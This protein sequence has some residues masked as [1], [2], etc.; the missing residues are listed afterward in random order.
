MEANNVAAM[1]EA[2]RNLVDAIRDYHEN[3]A[4]YVGRNILSVLAPQINAA[5]DALAAPLR[6]CDVGTPEEQEERFENYTA[7]HWHLGNT[8]LRWAQMPYQERE[9]ANGSK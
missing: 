7:R 8:K 9:E 5:Q 2:L 4:Q 3:A 1:H 6:N